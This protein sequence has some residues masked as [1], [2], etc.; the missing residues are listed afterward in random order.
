MS[1]YLAL[2]VVAAIVGFFAYAMAPPRWQS[3][4]GLLLIVAV[5]VPAGLVGITLLAKPAILIPVAFFIGVL[6][7]RAS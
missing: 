4:L 2:A 3:P 5:L 6:V 7:S 1:D